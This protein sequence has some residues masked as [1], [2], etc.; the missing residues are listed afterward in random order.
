MFSLMLSIPLYTGLRVNI[1]EALTLEAKAIIIS[2]TIEMFTSLSI[3]TT[4]SMYLYLV[5]SLVREDKED[6]VFEHLFSSPLPPLKIILYRFAASIPFLIL[7][8]AIISLLD[9]LAILIAVPDVPS[10]TYSSIALLFILSIIL[11]LPLCYIMIFNGLIIPQKYFIAIILIFTLPIFSTGGLA[12][13][14]S[15]TQPTPFEAFRLATIIVSVITTIVG[16]IETVFMKD[17]MVEMI[18]TA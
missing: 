3:V 5:S 18:I 10:I 12:I 9:F 11:G 15:A 1:S 2:N 7:C 13:L 4:S 14:L 8:C 6:K 16:L 17:R